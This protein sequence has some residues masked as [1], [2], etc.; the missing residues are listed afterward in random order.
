M[1]PGDSVGDPALLAQ[2]VADALQ[3]AQEIYEDDTIEAPVP[4]LTNP[5]PLVALQELTAFGQLVNAQAPLRSWTPILMYP[6]SPAEE[7]DL[8]LADANF[9]DGFIRTRLEDPFE[10]VT[11]EI[12]DISA[13]SLPS[14][15][16]AGIPSDA[17]AIIATSNSGPLVLVRRESGEV[18]REVNAGWNDLQTLTIIAPTDAGWREWDTVVEFGGSA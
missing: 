1:A 15:T 12:V 3:E 10:Y 6:G 4:D 11:L 18:A 5:D 14:E 2:Q 8:D 13:I 9:F 17:V 16:A 7:L